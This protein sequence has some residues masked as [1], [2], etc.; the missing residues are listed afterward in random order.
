MI[1]DRGQMGKSWQGCD[2]SRVEGGAKGNGRCN[3]GHRV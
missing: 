1:G 2:G 3:Q